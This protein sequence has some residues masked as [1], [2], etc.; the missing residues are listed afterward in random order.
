MFLKQQNK[1][2]ESENN[3][4]ELELLMLPGSKDD[5]KKSKDSNAFDFD[6]LIAKAERDD[7]EEGIVKRK[8]KGKK[9]RLREKQMKAK[10]GFK[11]NTEDPRFSALY[12][13]P[14]DFNIDPTHQQLNK[15]IT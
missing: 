13:R 9:E 2:N 3:E 8:R 14:H 15:V 1:K 11:I 4:A 7:N 5:G 6:K 10:G 12:S